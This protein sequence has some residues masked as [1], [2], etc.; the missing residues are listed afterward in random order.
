VW[1]KVKNRDY[2][3]ARDRWKLLDRRVA[4]SRG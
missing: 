2:S 1:V 3:Q 4:A